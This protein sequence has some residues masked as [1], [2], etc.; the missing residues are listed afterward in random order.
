MAKSSGATWFKMFLRNKEIFDAVPDETAGKAIKAAM[1]YAQTGTPP[2]LDQL[3]NV[4]FCA[5]RPSIDDSLADFQVI[6]ERNRQ[7]GAKGGRPKQ[8]T[9][10]QKNPSNPS[11]PN[12]F[13]K[14]QKKQKK[15]D[16]REKIEDRGQKIEESK[17]NTGRISGESAQAA[18]PPRTRFTAPSET[19]A[20]SFFT[21]QC[22]NAREAV[23]FLDYYTANGWKVGRNPMKD[24]KAAAR[25]WIRRTPPNT[26][27][28]TQ[29]PQANY[30]EQLDRVAQQLAD[31][32]L[33][34]LGGLYE[35]E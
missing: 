31:G 29:G 28:P 23:A 21:E 8:D 1:A 26:R 5:L 2:E 3:T 20:I 27:A 32:N 14:T 25:N 9:A 6:R 35:H 16:R 22:G 17:E 12:G 34:I 19:E 24:W 10:D 30:N 13:L 18:K 4:V 15:E 11:K 33:S 7:N